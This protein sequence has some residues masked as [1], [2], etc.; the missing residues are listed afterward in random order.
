VTRS[1]AAVALFF[2][3][4]SVACATA[5]VNME[6]PRR[7]VGTE[8]SVRVDAEIRGE[9]LRSGSPLPI[10]WVITNQRDKT[11]A[12]ADVLPLATYDKETRVVTVDIG[13]EVPGE[14]TLPRLV[15]IAPGEKR[16][17]AGNARLNFLV[18]PR[19]SGMR[20]E[21][22]AALRIKVNFLGDVEPF[23]EL[24]NIPERAVADPT[25][26]SSLFPVWLERNEVLY[27]NAIPMRWTSRDP[28]AGPTPTPAPTRTRKP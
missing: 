28:M 21:A 11:I 20:N 10:T 6:E 4:F 25:L 23:R 16:T 12:V 13:A 27:T 19:T 18:S 3:L 9:E 15:T 8:S 17:F 26:A 14:E 5:P 7:V 24:L 1:P 2:V 22:P